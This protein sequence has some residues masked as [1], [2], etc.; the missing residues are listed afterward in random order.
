[1]SAR[2][3]TNYDAPLF[4]VDHSRSKGVILLAM[5]KQGSVPIFLSL[6]LEQGH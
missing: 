4:T 3:W 2:K 5:G 6:I 1:M